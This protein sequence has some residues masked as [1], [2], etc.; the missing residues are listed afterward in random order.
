MLQFQ[1]YRMLRRRRTSYAVKY[2]Y[3]ELGAISDGGGRREART[4]GRAF[5]L[6]GVYEYVYMIRYIR[7]GYDIHVV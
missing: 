2:W 7:V 5:L 4:A 1:I 3:E 6:L